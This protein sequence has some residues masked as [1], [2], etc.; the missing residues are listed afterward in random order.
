M[1][2][3]RVALV[4]EVFGSEDDRVRLRTVLGEARERGA[5]LAVLPELPLN[6]WSP[7]TREARPEDAEP[8]AGPRHAAL[9]AA[10]RAAGIGVIGGAIV[11]EEKTARRFNTALVFDAEGALVATTRKAHL[12][13]EPG[14]WEPSHY[15]PADE[16]PALVTAFPLPLGV[17]L[18]SDVNRPIGTQL[19]AAAGAELVVAPRATEA[20]TWERWKLVLRANA[21]TCACFILSVNRPAPENGVPLGGP[22]VAIAPDGEVLLETTERLAVVELDRERVRSASAGYPGYLAWRSNLYAGGWSALPD[23][24]RHGSS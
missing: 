2:G 16:P 11:Q 23:V 13:D 15:D 10:A 20:S 1:S 19:L 18:C 8:P 6:P 22:S 9:A 24:P 14:F 21:L 7:A 5:E 4:H 3:M 17:Q 12:P